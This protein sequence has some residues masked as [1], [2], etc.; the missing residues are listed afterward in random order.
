[1][2]APYRWLRAAIDLIDALAVLIACLALFALMSLVVSDVALRYFINAPLTWSYEVISNFLMPGLFF[3]SVSHTLKANAH[4]AVDIVHNYLGDR[5]RYVLEAINS[6]LICPVFAVIAYFSLRA[7]LD[8]FAA[9]DVMTSGLELPSWT[10]SFLSPL[11]FALLAL[12]TGLNALGYVGS[13][14]GPQPLLELP[15]IS[16]TEENYE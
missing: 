5:T 16:G 4:V 2:L 12:R 3:L 15:A 13:L 1:M 8:Q 9:G 7:T 10:T 11:G 14:I 6:A